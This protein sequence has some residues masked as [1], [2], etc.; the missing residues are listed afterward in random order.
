MTVGAE[1]QTVIID[2]VLHIVEYL[3]VPA[4][5][6]ISH[7]SEGIGL[8]FGGR[9]WLRVQDERNSQES[10]DP[11][12]ELIPA[13]G[14]QSILNTVPSGHLHFCRRTSP[15]R[16]RES[17]NTLYRWCSSSSNSTIPASTSMRHHWNRKRG[18]VCPIR[19]GSRPDN[20][21]NEV[22]RQAL[23]DELPPRGARWSLRVRYSWRGAARW[24]S[25][26]CLELG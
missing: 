1:R 19:R 21:S 15:P 2:Q 23:G 4:V 10:F 13:M 7:A 16:I 18:S 20:Y 9:S 25:L 11:F 17:Q 3:G 12:D 24:R 26:E 8:T 5:G 22:L 14:L 6:N